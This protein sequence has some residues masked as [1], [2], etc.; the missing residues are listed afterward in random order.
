[1]K[2]FSKQMFGSSP[3]TSHTI[4]Q[5]SKKTTTAPSNPQRKPSNTGMSGL[6]SGR[7]TGRTR[8][9]SCR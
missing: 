1:M 4:S 3:R 5:G 6:P 2:V 9:A 7:G 8:C